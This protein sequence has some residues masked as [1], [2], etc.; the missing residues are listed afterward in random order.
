MGITQSS[1]GNARKRM[2]PS[3]FLSNSLRSVP[4]AANAFSDVIKNHRTVLEVELVSYQD[5]KTWFVFEVELDG[6]TPI[7]Q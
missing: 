3:L 4:V 7:S 2:F 5:R 1:T 6:E